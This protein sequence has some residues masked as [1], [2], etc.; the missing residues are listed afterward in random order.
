MYIC[1]GAFVSF[2]LNFQVD[3]PEVHTSA[4]KTFITVVVVLLVVD[5]GDETTVA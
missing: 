2:Y 3:G 1:F 5:D 4:V